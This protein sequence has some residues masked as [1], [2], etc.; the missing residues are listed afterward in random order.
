MSRGVDD[1]VHKDL[2]IFKRPVPPV[3]GNVGEQAVL[4]F[5]PFARFRREVA[6]TDVKAGANVCSSSFHRWERHLVEPSPSVV[7]K[8]SLA[9]G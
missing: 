2:A 5:V 7:I 6:D 3:L 4:H 9:S 1:Q 8:T